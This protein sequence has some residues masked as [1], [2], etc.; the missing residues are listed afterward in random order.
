MASRR[1]ARVAQRIKEEASQVVLYELRD[2]RIGLVTITKVDVSRDLRHAK[3]YFSVLGSEN[4]RRTVER[5]LA[6]ALGLVRTR[7]AQSL[8]L[9]EAP[10]ISFHFDPSVEKAIE[11]SKLIDQVSAEL[12]PDEDNGEDAGEEE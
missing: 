4:K 1:A 9:R 12:H 10:S 5:G 3:I 7:I 8:Q 6:S 11:I 2:P